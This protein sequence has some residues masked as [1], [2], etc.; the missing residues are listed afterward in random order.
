[1]LQNDEEVYNR[2]KSNVEKIKEAL[3]CHY[4]ADITNAKKMISNTY[5]LLL[6][7]RNFNSNIILFL[8]YITAIY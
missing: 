6:H 5:N 4:D 8:Y 3:S 1:M 7:I 2:T